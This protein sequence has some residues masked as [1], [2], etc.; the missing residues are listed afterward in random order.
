MKNKK[1][2]E[3]KLGLLLREEIKMKNSNNFGFLLWK[4]AKTVKYISLN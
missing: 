1:K 3:R 2:Y 4:D